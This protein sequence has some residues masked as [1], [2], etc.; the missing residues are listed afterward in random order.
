LR[1]VAQDRPRTPDALCAEARAP[2]QRGPEIACEG[3][4]DI[5]RGV[6]RSFRPLEIPCSRNSRA[7][8]AF[9]IPSDDGGFPDELVE[10]R[11]RVRQMVGG[12]GLPG[13]SS[14]NCFAYWRLPTR[15]QSTFTERGI[16]A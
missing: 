11:D 1:E 9:H 7:S 15:R 10:A 13:N 4:P 6:R 3:I 8:H 5:G 16:P 14:L 12:T 2:G